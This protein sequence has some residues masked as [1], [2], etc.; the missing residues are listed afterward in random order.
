MATENAAA[1][2][3]CRFCLEPDSTLRNPLLSPCRCAGFGRYVHKHCL[4][5]WAAM[6]PARNSTTCPVCRA[7]YTIQILPL[8]EIIPSDRGWAPFCLRNIGWMSFLVKYICALLM[9]HDN[10]ISSLLYINIR[11]I[12]ICSTI[13]FLSVAIYNFKVRNMTLYLRAIERT[14]IPRTFLEHSIAVVSF[15]VR[16]DILMSVVMDI[17]MMTYW[18]EHLKALR[19]VNSDLMRE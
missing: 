7:P 16:K 8:F 19:R 6:D 4:Q 5:R 13:F 12:Q 17:C 14:Y 15:F 10:T 3:V 1:E 11:D 2:L 18:P 9:L